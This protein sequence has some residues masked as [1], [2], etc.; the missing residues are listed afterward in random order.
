MI[1]GGGVQK[2]PT[3]RTDSLL[4]QHSSEDCATRMTK[5]MKPI[6][7]HGYPEISPDR[8]ANFATWV[9]VVFFGYLDTKSPQHD[10]S[11]ESS[12][13]ELFR[14]VKTYL[15]MVGKSKN[16]K[17]LTTDKH[18]DTPWVFP[19]SNSNRKYVTRYNIRSSFAEIWWIPTDFTYNILSQT[20]EILR[21]SDFLL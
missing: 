17:E 13:A 18:T 11:P 20:I 14:N 5:C 1:Y 2:L 19:R 8:I 6:P 3:E 12:R 4:F 15:R 10:I 21:S 9:C 7:F 16:K